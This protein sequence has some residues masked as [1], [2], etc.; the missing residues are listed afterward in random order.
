MQINSFG[1][2]AVVSLVY[3]YSNPA[4]YVQNTTPHAAPIAP[5]LVDAHNTTL[6]MLP[7]Q[8]HT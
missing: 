4:L 8:Q 3:G 6:S 1:P 2:V 5:L 7:Q